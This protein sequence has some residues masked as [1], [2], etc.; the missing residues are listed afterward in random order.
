ML[1]EKFV[2]AVVVAAGSST[3]MKSD[4]SKQLLKIGDKT[5]LQ[6][7]VSAFER[8]GIVDEIIIVCPENDI[9]NFK[10][11]FSDSNVKIPVKFT[12]GGSTRQKSVGNG[13]SIVSE[14]CGVIAIHDG[15]RPLVKPA[16]IQRVI[17]DATTFGAAALAVPVKDTVKLVE[18]A[19][20]ESTPPRDKLFIIQTPQVF[21]KS[22]Y[23]KAYQKAVSDGNDFTDDCQLI[24]SVGGKVHITVGDYTNI[25]ITT[26]ED[27]AVAET[28]LNLR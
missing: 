25:K 19:V 9:E 4:I 21:D 18:N 22:T 11:L 3:R 24:E 7:T 5:V 12:I 2:S 26:A 20:V 27:I 1:N 15:A 17:E 23:I 14:S 28:F 8:S 13:V 16:D 6:H 10:L